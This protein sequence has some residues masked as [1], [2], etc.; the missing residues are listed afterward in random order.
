MC[1]RK[2]GTFSMAPHLEGLRIGV[3][4]VIL[5]LRAGILAICSKLVLVYRTL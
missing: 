1:R 3:F 4:D 5:N 2:Q